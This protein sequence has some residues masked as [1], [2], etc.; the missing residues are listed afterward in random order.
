LEY[1]FHHFRD[2]KEM[3]PIIRQMA[4]FDLTRVICLDAAATPSLPFP[5]KF[6]IFILRSQRR[7]ECRAPA[8]EDGRMQVV[9][10]S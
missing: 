10:A 1:K 8:K 3:G 5:K 2:E 4:A 9:S 7:D 6:R